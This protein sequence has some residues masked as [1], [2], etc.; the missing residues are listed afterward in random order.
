MQL[1]LVLVFV[2]HKH[3]Y[4]AA[5]C[6]HHEPTPGL[7]QVDGSCQAE[8]QAHSRMLCAMDVHPSKP[9]LVTAAEDATFAVWSLSASCDEV[10]HAAIQ[11]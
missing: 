4:T 7:L 5:R 10:G 3:G 6:K 2:P 9:L 8:I 11:P 1:T